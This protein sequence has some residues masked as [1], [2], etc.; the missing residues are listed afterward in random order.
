MTFL[1][2]WFKLLTN[3]VSFLFLE[4]EDQIVIYLFEFLRDIYSNKKAQLFHEKDF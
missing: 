2:V 3:V 1:S 4:N